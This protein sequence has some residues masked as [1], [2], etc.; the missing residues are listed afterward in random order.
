MTKILIKCYYY[1]PRRHECEMCWK[2]AET[3][4][5]YKSRRRVRKLLKHLRVGVKTGKLKV[6]EVVAA[7]RRRQNPPMPRGRRFRLRAEYEISYG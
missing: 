6:Y 7:R 4:R 2:D 3:W 5:R 1:D